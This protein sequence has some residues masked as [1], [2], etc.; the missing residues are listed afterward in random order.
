MYFLRLTTKR[1]L[2]EETFQREILTGLVEASISE[3]LLWNI[4]RIV[5]MIFMTEEIQMMQKMTRAC[6]SD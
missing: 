4:E 5:T 3:N 2:G 1:A 6:L